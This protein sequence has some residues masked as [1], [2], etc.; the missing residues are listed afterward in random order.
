MREPIVVTIDRVT[1]DGQGTAIFDG[2]KPGGSP[3][4]PGGGALNATV[5]VD[6]ARGVVVR[7]FTIQNSPG[8]GIIVQKNSSF[9]VQDTKILNN[10][11]GV[12][13]RDSSHAELQGCEITGNTDAGLGVVDTSAVEFTRQVRINQNLE[14][15]SAGGRCDL[16][17]SGE[18]L[19]A[20]GNKRNGISLSGCSFGPPPTLAGHRVVVNDNGTDGLFIGGGQLVIGPLEFFGFAGALFQQIVAHNNG[21]AVSIWQDSR[22]SSISEEASLI[23]REMPSV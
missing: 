23:C 12:L 15:I 11:F 22:R 3:Y 20:S 5:V 2:G 6:G 7:G 8:G 16:R 17:F 4:G 13:V 19:E 9:A 1:L 18:L 14:G 10:Y 21:A